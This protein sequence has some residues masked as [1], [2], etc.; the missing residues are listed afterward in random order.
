M[1]INYPIKKIYFRQRKQKKILIR[2]SET[3]LW[4][5]APSREIP[6]RGKFR[7]TALSQIGE[8]AA[9]SRATDN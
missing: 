1:Q 6:F 7:R 8:I 4:L 5:I 9:F 2:L 3:R